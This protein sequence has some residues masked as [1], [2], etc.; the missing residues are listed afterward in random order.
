MYYILSCFLDLFIFIKFLFE[1]PSFPKTS[2][3]KW[4]NLHFDPSKGQGFLAKNF[5]RT[6]VEPER[7]VLCQL[8]VLLTKLIN[9]N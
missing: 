7:M 1:L 6:N 3:L 8:L 5:I 2:K 9:I 4:K